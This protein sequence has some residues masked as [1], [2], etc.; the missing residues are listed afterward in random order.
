MRATLLL[1]I[2]ALLSIGLE[3]LPPPDHARLEKRS[4]SELE[5]RVKAIDLELEKLS[6]L[7][8]RSGAGSVGCQSA[9]HLDPNHTEWV[10][11]DLG[12][13]T[14]F[15]QVV[16]VPTIWR[17]SKTGFNAT[18][19]PVQFQ[20]RAGTDPDSEGIVLASFT[21]KAHLTPRTAPIVISCETTASWVRVEASILSQGGWDTRYNLEL[22]ELILFN[23]EENVA[24]RKPVTS[25]SVS[26]REG[27]SRQKE[28][29]VDGFV[30]YVM[31]AGRGTKHIPFASNYAI[32]AQ[33]SILIDLGATYPINRIHL[34]SSDGSDSVPKPISDG[35]GLP[36]LLVMEGAIQA[37]F[38]D[39]VPLFEYRHASIFDAGPIIMRRFPG[40]RCRYVR[41][42]ALE[43]YNLNSMGF[44][45]IEVFSNGENKALHKPADAPHKIASRPTHLLTDGCNLYGR[46]L[47]VRQWMNE[48][49]LRHDLES[50][51]P[52]IT[53]E[54]KHRYEQRKINLWRMSG[55]ASLLAGGI[56]FT[57][58]IDRLF[59]MRQI[60]GM[61]ERFAA[62]LHDELGANLHAI[63]ILGELAK[64]SSASHDE[65]EGT[66]DEIC[67][68]AGRTGRATRYCIDQY[69]HT[70][71]DLPKEMRRTS[72]RIL[73][74]LAYDIQIEGETMLSQLQPAR[75]HDFLLFFKE[76]LVNIS[77]HS[78]ASRVDIARTAT[79]NEIRLAIRDNGKGFEGPPPPSLKRRARLL[80]GDIAST[81]TDSG[82]VCITLRFR[83]GRGFFRNR[84]SQRNTSD[85]AP[86]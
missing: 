41:L 30:P 61:K 63:G 15:D 1:F 29:L 60:A 8:M 49:A 54:L 73:A 82:G 59:R 75:Q 40:N 67:G 19:L 46:I 43:P 81:S 45:E 69:A 74:D 9:F 27:A 51:H 58:L 76:S 70:Q 2:A 56:V 57:V 65:L 83:P 21:K 71:L 64:D 34:H 32:G 13:P 55:L 62:D 26:P 17:D 36:G 12:Q 84:I 7:S 5:Q 14:P 11:V 16:L 86:P 18:G 72:R 50:E 47:P 68:L 37:D 3:A 77:R 6:R 20:I 33:P 48:L 39:A 31:D 80:R 44:A 10:E 35:H 22:A 42:T 52:R 38:S 25:S 28:F 66:L 85:A 79:A 23:G 4:T 24:L 78:N 53:A